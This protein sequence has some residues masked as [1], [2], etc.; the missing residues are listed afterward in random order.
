MLRVIVKALENSFNAVAFTGEGKIYAFKVQDPVNENLIV[1]ELSLL[2][3]A[4]MALEEIVKDCE[5][6]VSGDWLLTVSK[7]R[8]AYIADITTLGAAQADGPRGLLVASNVDYAYVRSIAGAAIIMLITGNFVCVYRCNV[9]NAPFEIKR[10]QVDGAI[11]A[12]DNRA[13][14]PAE[15][16][17]NMIVRAA[18]CTVFCEYVLD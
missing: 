17:R 5:V 1:D 4:G 15:K 6:F 8:K 10:V 18:N 3:R 16:N 9:N 13:L 11:S 14:L 2:R 12:I 7:D